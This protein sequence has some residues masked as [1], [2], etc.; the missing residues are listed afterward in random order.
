MW[1]PANIDIVL[2][3]MD[4][5]EAGLESIH[6]PPGPLCHHVVL[7]TSPAYRRHGIAHELTARTIMASQAT[8]HVGVFAEATSIRS[9][10]LFTKR[11]GFHVA[12][13]LC[14]ATWEYKGTGTFPLAALTAEDAS[15]CDLVV[16]W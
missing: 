7:S 15:W 5:L 8:G 11:Y 6:P 12:S 16:T 9:S 3:L 4:T 1:Q 2:A 10:G 14:Y 13:R